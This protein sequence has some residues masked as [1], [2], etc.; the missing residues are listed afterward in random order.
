MDKKRCG[1]TIER[2]KTSTGVVYSRRTCKAYPLRGY[3]H[4]RYHLTFEE[5]DRYRQEYGYA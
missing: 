3:D 1:G 2:G 5:Y 4:C